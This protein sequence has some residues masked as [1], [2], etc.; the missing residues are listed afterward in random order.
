MIKE[1]HYVID[2]I[3]HVRDV[4]SRLLYVLFVQITH[5][6]FWIITPRLVIVKNLILML[7]W[8]NVILV[9]THVK[10]VKSLLIIVYLV[11]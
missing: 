5:L 1:F 11:P 4:F 3:I 8:Q 9:I 10:H 7:E 2:V 6:E